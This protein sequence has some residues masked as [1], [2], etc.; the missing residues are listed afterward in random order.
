MSDSRRLVLSL[1]ILLVFV[2][3]A[4]LLSSIVNAVTRTWDGGG[5]TNDWSDCVNWSGDT[6][7]TGADAVVFNSTSTKNATIDA[8]FTGT[9]LSMNIN[10]GYTGIITQARSLT[11]TG[12]YTQGA[13]TFTG[14]SQAIDVTGNLN[15]FVVTAGSFT[16]TSGTLSVKGDFN[17]ASATFTHNGGTVTF[18]ENSTNRQIT[19]NSNTLNLVTFTH[20]SPYKRVNSSC[21]LPMGS[22]PSFSGRILLDGGTLSGTGTLTAGAQFDLQNGASFPDFPAW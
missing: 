10:S 18:T 6:C 5:T 13:G 9:V 17:V 8:S 2:I 14:G 16:S 11:I 12:A 4:F 22:N 7:P 21:S 1:V 20:T 3:S 15:S 19:C